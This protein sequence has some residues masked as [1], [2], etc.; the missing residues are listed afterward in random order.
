MDKQEDATTAAAPERSTW[1]FPQKTV[2]QGQVVRLEPLSPAHLGDLW[3]RV[4]AAPE[5]FAFLRYGPFPSIQ[6]LQIALAD[7]SNRADQPFWAVIGPEGSALGW[8]SLCDISQKH[9]S[10]EIGSVWF[11]ATLQGSR[12]GRE[13]LFLLMSLA[14]DDLSYERLVWRCQALNRKSFQAA[15]SL[16]FQ[17]EGIWRKGQI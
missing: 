9:S 17:H 14:M 12:A 2:L 11:S 1:D 16:G 15:L 6:D 8:L 3:P 10:I 7:F 5:S 4:A 13:A